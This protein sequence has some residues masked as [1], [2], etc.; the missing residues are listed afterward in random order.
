MTKKIIK[1]IEYPLLPLER[2]KHM[3]T[4]AEVLRRLLAAKEAR[5]IQD[6]WL[7]FPQRSCCFSFGPDGGPVPIGALFLLW[8]AGSPFVQ[9]C[10]DCGGRM[11]MI[12]FGGLL[13]IGGGRLVCAGCGFAFYQP[14]GNLGRVSEILRKSPLARTQFR[15][16]GAHFGGAHSSD[17]AQLFA[18]LGVDLPPD[19]ATPDDEVSLS[20]KNL[21][22]AVNLAAD[23]T[24]REV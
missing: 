17:G 16:T 23:A 15:P 13:V 19:V 24:T 5:R 11:Y 1:G 14:L 22:F 2:R 9:D 6:L 18:F 7:P 3:P 12:S 10:R 8:S 20:V 4:T 21:K